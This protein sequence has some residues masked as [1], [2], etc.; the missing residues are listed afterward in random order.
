MYTEAI[1]GFV[2]VFDAATGLPITVLS[3]GAPSF[4]GVA[5]AEG[6]AFATVGTGSSGSGAVVA[7]AP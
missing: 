7:F 2:E 3:L 6:A 4:G 1:P 5:L